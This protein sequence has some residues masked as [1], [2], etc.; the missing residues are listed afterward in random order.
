MGKRT[1]DPPS[2]LVSLKTLA[3]YLQLDPTTVSVVLNVGPWTFH[4]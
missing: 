1:I 2:G 4:S 3:A